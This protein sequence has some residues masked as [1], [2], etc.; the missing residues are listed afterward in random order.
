MLERIAAYPGG[1]NS[2]EQ[3]CSWE[4][5]LVMQGAEQMEGRHRVALGAKPG[6]HSTTR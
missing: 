3:T 2:E 1:H 4:A 5:R 6:R